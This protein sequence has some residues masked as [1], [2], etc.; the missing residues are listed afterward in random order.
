MATPG[1]EGTYEMLWDCEFCGQKKNLGLTHR[2]CP[3][4]GAE[5]DPKLRYFPSDADKIAVKDHVFVG[6]DRVCKSCGAASSAK[7]SHCG[8][9]GAA[10]DDAVAAVTRADQ[11]QAEGGGFAGEASS[12]AAKAERKAAQAAA[13]PNVKPVAKPAAPAGPAPSRKWIWAVGGIGVV[14]TGILFAALWKKTAG[15]EVTGHTWEREVRVET[16]GPQSLSDWCDQLPG[17]AMHVTR[18]REVRSHEQVADGEECSMRRVDNGDGTF[19]QKRECKPK[20]KDSPV[21]GD[22]CHY[23]A[24]RWKYERSLRATGG[25]AQTPAWPR[26][27]LRTGM[28]VGCEREAG[29][30][31]SYTLSL[32]T[33]PDGK[34]KSCTLDQSRWA[35]TRDGSKWTVE[36]GVMTGLADCSTMKPQ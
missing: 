27:Q 20:Y 13:N 2:H 11:V 19:K 31:E 8:Q 33:I 14:V 30:N 3:N 22:K 18:T 12:A 5:Q 10:A 17:D 24:N 26:A 28:C 7:A 35:A 9:C 6:A 4:C 25:L 16:F 34:D 36:I 21:Y 23:T 29:N 32:K 1:D 15:V